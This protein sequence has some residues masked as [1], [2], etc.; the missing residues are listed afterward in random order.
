MKDNGSHVVLSCQEW[1][2]LID[3]SNAKLKNDQHFERFEEIISKGKT[4]VRED[5]RILGY[6]IETLKFY[7]TFSYLSNKNHRYFIGEKVDRFL[8]KISVGLISYT[9]VKQF[10]LYFLWYYAPE[11]FRFAVEEL[12]SPPSIF[13]W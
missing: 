4:V 5:G 2:C 8:L 7:D 1:S 11:E 9:I 6:N 10:I 13:F 12:P 3:S